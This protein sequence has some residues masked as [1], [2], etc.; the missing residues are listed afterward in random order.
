VAETEDLR[1]FIREITLRFERGM[2]RISR[3]IREDSRKYFET[4]DA[5]QRA[6]HEEN[7]EKLEQR[8]RLDEILAEGRAGRQA[9]FRMLDK[10]DGG[11]TAPAG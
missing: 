6:R 2:E 4:I 10:L 1:T 3:E 9:L 8:E 11:G 7:R 5:E